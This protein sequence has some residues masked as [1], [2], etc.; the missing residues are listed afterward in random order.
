MAHKMKPNFMM[1]GR[2]DLMELSLSIEKMGKAKQSFV[3]LLKALKVKGAARVMIKAMVADF[4]S[5]EG[6]LISI[7]DELL[8][9]R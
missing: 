5:N 1:F 2:S 8:L 9:G 3:Q 4:D 7:G 6:W